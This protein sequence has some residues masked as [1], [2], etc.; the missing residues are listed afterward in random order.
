MRIIFSW[1]Y[2]F[3]GGKSHFAPMDSIT[4]LWKH[5]L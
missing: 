4:S 2:S 3:S 5:A 1:N